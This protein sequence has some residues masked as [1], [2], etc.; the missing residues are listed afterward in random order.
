MNLLEIRKWFIK[1][2]GRYDLVTDPETCAQENG[3]D[4]YIQ[5][6]QRLLDSLL[7]SPKELVKVTKELAINASL[8]SLPRFRSIEFVWFENSDGIRFLEK[9]T[10]IEIK[11]RF[12]TS[13]DEI[14]S[15]TPSVYSLSILRSIEGN[16]EE[17]QRNTAIRILVPT[18]TA[19]EVTIIGSFPSDA[20]KQN[21]DTNFW[22]LEYPETLVQAGLYSLERF[23]R[24]T[25]GMNDH[26]SAIMQDVRGIDFDVVKQEIADR[27]QMVSSFNERDKLRRY[28]GDF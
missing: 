16:N 25:Q 8:I 3:S 11:E 12:P 4:K 22:S 10:E 15:G 1:D 28:Y 2:S 24:N 20:L 17:Q 21:K 6:G 7:D 27:D 18:D 5:A 23:Y 14:E 19:L 9:L 26:M 13:L